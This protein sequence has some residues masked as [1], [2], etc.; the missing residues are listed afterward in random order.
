MCK[1]SR[2]WA[3]G[4]T[5]TCGLAWDALATSSLVSLMRQSPAPVF[6]LWPHSAVI[7]HLVN[8]R[9][10]GS[11]LKE[12]ACYNSRAG[13]S[14]FI[15]IASSRVLLRWEGTTS[16]VHV[17]SRICVMRSLDDRVSVLSWRCPRLI[18]SS[19]PA[20]FSISGHRGLTTTIE[21]L[22]KGP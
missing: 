3:L 5:N 15:A 22:E 17:W 4:S 14:T 13:Q 1:Y 2:D 19:A 9:Y 20:C 8:T 21:Q 10:Y 11:E 12:Q 16:T 18:R 7:L 6:S